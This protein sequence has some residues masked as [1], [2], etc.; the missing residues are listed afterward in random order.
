MKTSVRK[1][2]VVPGFSL[3]AL[4][5]SC[6]WSRF[7]D[8]TDQPAIVVL[9]APGSSVGR[10]L[11]VRGENGR[12]PVLFTGALLGSGAY[13]NVLG[14]PESPNA[15]ISGVKFEDP[16][17]ISQ[18]GK[19]TLNAGT[20]AYVGTSVD[21]AGS[22]VSECWV[23]GIRARPAYDDT[24]IGLAIT[25]VPR[26]GTVSEDVLAT[27][28]DKLN[29]SPVDPNVAFPTPE[30]RFQ[31]AHQNDRVLRTIEGSP[32]VA[33]TS[34]LLFPTLVAL[35]SWAGASLA[36]GSPDVN[37]VFV[38][39]VAGPA[40]AR[41]K[42]E[43]WGTQNPIT[44]V[45]LTRAENKG[46]FGAAVATVPAT[47]SSPDTLGLVVAEPTSGRLFLYD[48]DVQTRTSK[49]RGC[50][51]GEALTG[52][53]LHAYVDKEQRLVAASNAAG[54]VLVYDFDAIA[55][56]DACAPATPLATLRCAD[57]ADVVGC[58]DGAFGY[59]LTHGDLDGDGDQE[60]LVGAPGMNAREKVNSGALYLYDLEGG[61]G[62][63]TD[64]L[65][66]GNPENQSLL[67][68]SLA[69][70]R[71]GNRDIPVSGA[72]GKSDVYLFYCNAL[73]KASPR[74]Q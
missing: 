39:P 73:S 53:V 45:E 14:D 43:V 62:A 36:V 29:D 51:Q 40:P 61:S 23:H 71:S 37:S 70:A 18:L 16:A 4:T 69:V 34:K 46:S 9:H 32:Q 35:G 31:A 30:A 33:S 49:P 8:A 63:T 17:P 65:F 48:I 27:G 64:V 25:C 60:L 58:A 6:S 55:K 2:L 13:S 21:S 12:S 19:T 57:T 5:A 72:P 54:T 52:V 15:S 41:V 66:V 47:A 50:V 44:I 26:N 3:L 59:S 11:D 38:Y 22:D 10:W 42:A 1:L 24:K 74:C 68:S 28:V 67:G 20:V 56:D 7:D